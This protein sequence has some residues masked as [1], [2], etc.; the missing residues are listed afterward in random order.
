MT[1]A[2]DNALLL[3]HEQGVLTEFAVTLYRV[4]R[5]MLSRMT[6]AGLVA[7]HRRHG[8]RLTPSGLERCR[9]LEK[10]G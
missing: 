3:I 6:K 7:W 10:A 4:R 5:D 2:Q 1:K 8:W 9:E